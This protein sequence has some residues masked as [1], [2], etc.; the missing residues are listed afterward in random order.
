MLK[1]KFLLGYDRERKLIMK[2]ERVKNRLYI[3]NLDH[4][5]PICLMSSMEDLAWEWHTRYVHLN[6]QALRQLGQKQMVRGLPC[7]DH[8]EQLCDGCLTGKQR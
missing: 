7:V 4:V 2:V 8:V 1:D 3:L 6:F 5:D